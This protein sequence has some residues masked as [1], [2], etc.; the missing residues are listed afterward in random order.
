[1][2]ILHIN[3]EADLGPYLVQLREASGKSQ[4]QA[5]ADIGVNPGSLGKWEKGT[6]PSI[7]KLNVVLRYYGET[8]TFGRD[9]NGGRL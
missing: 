2:D 4:R 5:A 1:M 7:G 6:L 9:P 3:S 8:V